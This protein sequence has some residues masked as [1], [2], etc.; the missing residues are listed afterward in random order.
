[1]NNINLHFYWSSLK[2]E[3]TLFDLSRSYTYTYISKI[4]D[5]TYTY[6]YV[7]CQSLS[8][9]RLFAIPGTVAHQAPLSMGILQA[10]ILEWV[11]ISFSRGSS[12]ARDR[13]HTSYVSCIGRRVLY[14]QRHLGR[15]YFLG[16]VFQIFTALIT[17]VKY[18][19]F[20]NST[21][22]HFKYGL[23]Q[24][25][26][27]ALNSVKGINDSRKQTYSYGKTSRGAECCPR[28]INEE[29]D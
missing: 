24:F 9:V 6:T 28:V 29:D 12:R 8:H 23:L 22:C 3:G 7:Q 11:A 20:I 27:K 1:M 15:P 4:F 10:K 5:F 17:W 26:R 21:S 13:T 16:P 25:Q 14:H 19:G 2:F 18:R